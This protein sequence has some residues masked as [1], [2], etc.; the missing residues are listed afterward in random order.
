MLSAVSG[1]VWGLGGFLVAMHV[2][3]LDLTITLPFTKILLFC[4]SVTSTSFCSSFCVYFARVRIFVLFQSLYYLFPLHIFRI[5]FYFYSHFLYCDIA[6]SP[7]VFTT[8]AVGCCRMYVVFADPWTM[9]WHYVVQWTCEYCIAVHYLGVVVWDYPYIACFYRAP[10]RISTDSSRC[11]GCRRVEARFNV[12]NTDSSSCLCGV[13]AMILPDS[14]LSHCAC[15]LFLRCSRDHTTSDN[16]LQGH[17]TPVIYL[18]EA[19][20]PVTTFNKD[21]N[22][23][24]S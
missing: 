6:L 8:T 10:K 9:V 22:C 12:K 11:P 7:N 3:Y 15:C 1:R 14:W 23:G 17:I 19:I 13:P 2:G 18:R 21:N 20:K 16:V 4:F 5:F 24:V